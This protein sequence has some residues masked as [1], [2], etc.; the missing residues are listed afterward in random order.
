M[1]PSR[2][3]R[4]K[5]RISSLTQCDFAAAGEQMTIWNCDSCSARDSVSP[6][7]VA[8]RQLVAVAEDRRDPRRHD[9]L[10]SGRADQ[11]LRDAIGLEALV[12]PR[13]P[14]LVAVAVADERAVS[15]LLIH[16]RRSVSATR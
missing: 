6:R 7:L 3:R 9:A 10:R 16:R 4:L 1:R 2:P 8:R 5:V 14:V 13:G 12:Q 11:L 15:V